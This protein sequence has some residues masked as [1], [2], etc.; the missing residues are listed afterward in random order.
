[1]RNV[2]VRPVCRA[3]GAL[4]VGVALAAAVPAL[5]ARG[6]LPTAL[7]EVSLAELPS[8]ARTT[9]RLIFKG[10]P[11]PYDKDGT[12]FGNRE[13]LLP[14]HPT[15]LLPRIHRQNTV[16]PRSWGPAHCVWRGAADAAAGL[17]LHQRPLQQFSEDPAMS[18][19]D[20]EG[21]LHPAIFGNLWGSALS[22]TPTL[23]GLGGQ[24]TSYRKNY[25]DGHTV[26][27]RA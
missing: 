4:V 25:G 11:F 24:L 5:Q 17:L 1:M 2:I 3:A 9:Y 18:A 12:V 23:P 20:L 19:L 15:G 21:E 6:A 8:Q 14:S 7:P 10:G 16:G 27:S 22:I 13:R 26:L